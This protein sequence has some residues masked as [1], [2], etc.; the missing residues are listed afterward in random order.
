MNLFI[1]TAL[2]QIEPL[3]T[4]A[5]WSEATINPI[6]PIW[7]MAI[8]CVVICVLKRK[9]WVSYVRQILVALLLFG[10]NLRVMVPDPNHVIEA[11]N[12]DA[13]VLF[14]VDSTISMLGDDMGKD[15][16]RLDRAK[17]DIQY[18]V[19]QMEGSKFA[20]VD[21]NNEGKLITPYTNDVNR[22]KTAISVISPINKNY[23]QGSSFEANIE[24]IEEQIKIA[25]DKEDANIYVFFISD[26]EAN[27]DEKI[28]GFST[29]KKYLNGGAV[30]GYGTSKG[31]NMKVP[32]YSGYETVTDSMGNPAVTKL[33]EDNLVEIA[34]Q[35]DVSYVHM[36]N[37]SNI[38][39]VISDILSDLELTEAENV[40]V[41]YRETYYYLLPFL[42]VLLIWDFVHYKRKV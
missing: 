28:E 39:S 21:F 13:Y 26:G 23:A 6:I 19:D 10:I 5:E 36:K 40:I 25:Y 3:P 18:I 42:I 35:M 8:V 20:V 12:Y 27:Q 38:D 7:V 14:A 1:N 31:G 24:S 4:L 2:L 34:N 11:P 15:T 37:Q 33:N 29:L 9:G 30:L 32:T 41:A 22:V 17:E 16:T